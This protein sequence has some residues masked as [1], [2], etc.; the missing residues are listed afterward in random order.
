MNDVTKPRLAAFPKCYMDQLCVHR[1][2]TLFEWIELAA[3][4]GVEGL[5]FY[6]G[7]LEDDEAFL[8][9]SKLHSRE[10]NL[11]MPMLCCSPDFTQPDPVLSKKR[12]SA[13]SG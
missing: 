8:K 4:L 6:S 13:K 11:A 2:M 1:T 3:T 10:H 7:F 5:E 9:R 12:L